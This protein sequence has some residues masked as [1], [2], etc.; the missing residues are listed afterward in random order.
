MPNNSYSILNKDEV[1]SVG[2]TVETTEDIPPEAGET[3]A[4]QVAYM[5]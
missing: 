4:K 3:L 2:V 5:V 1:A